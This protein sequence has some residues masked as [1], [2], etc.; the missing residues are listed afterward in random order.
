[1]TEDGKT[2]KEQY[3]WEARSQWHSEPFQGD[4]EVDIKLFHGDKRIRDIDNY[5]KILLDAL[6]G[7]LWYDDKQIQ[8]MTI[9][10]LYDKENPRIEINTFLY[11]KQK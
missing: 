8:K 2:M 1:M 6:T 3:Q 7:I 11:D 10:K 5:N 4:I 9:T